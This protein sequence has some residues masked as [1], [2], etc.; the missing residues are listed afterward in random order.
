MDR[1]Q[2][3]LTPPRLATP[4]A[5]TVAM[6]TFRRPDDLAVAIPRVL[7]QSS[8]I[9]PAATLLI[10]DNDPAA[11]AADAVAAFADPRVRYVHEPRPGIAAARNRALDEVADD[12]LL[13][14]ID[15][16]ERP[17]RRLAAE[18]RRHVRPH[19]QCRRGR[20][21]RLG[22]RRRTRPVD[23]AR[24]A[25]SIDAA[26][27]P[28]RRID[29]AATNNL[30]LDMTQVRRLGLEFDEA[31]GISGGSDT[32][33]SRQLV[34]RGA[35]MVWCDEAVV[36]DQVPA[37]Q[38][39]ARVGAR[40]GHSALA[41]PG[42]GHRP[43]SRRHR[44][45]GCARAPPAWP[46]GSSASWEA[47]GG[48]LPVPRCGRSGCGR[49]AAAPC[50]AAP[51][52][53]RP[54]PAT[55]ST[56]TGGRQRSARSRHRCRDR[57]RRGKCAPA[58]RR[59][60]QLRLARAARGEPDLTGG[61]E[62]SRRDVRRRRQLHLARRA[63][64]RRGAVPAARVGPGGP[65]VQPWL[66]GRSERGGGLRSAP[67]LRRPAPAEPRRVDRLGLGR[68]PR[69]SMPAPAAV[70][71]EPGDRASGRLCL[72]SRRSHRPGHRRPRRRAG[73]PSSPD[74]PP[75]S[76]AHASSSARAC[77]TASAGSTSGTSCI[78]RTSTCPAAA[79]SWA[80]A[81]ASPLTQSPTTTSAPRSV[82]RGRAG[83]SRRRTTTTT[84][85]TGCR[86]PQ[87]TSHRALRCAGARRRP[88]RAGGSCCAAAA[89][90]RW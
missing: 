65:A 54:Q 51:G 31:F 2:S 53:W 81:S 68:G 23:R 48:S 17:A 45:G 25:S 3:A 78:G 41:T 85:A 76:P 61:G 66:R 14:F 47:P 89:A 62:R 37:R 15:D 19:G 90:G 22:L 21:S 27:P 72:V 9:D 34:A 30:L 56:S 33:F 57:S 44:P 86:S 83:R 13:I 7:A 28:E 26:C 59:R 8:D 52:W 69:E 46:L 71:A 63:G 35:S 49:T 12:G 42:C 80:A 40:S 67:R 20:A 64:S 11:S 75:G 87:G 55:C 79:S 58:R 39:H 18:P 36:T 43:H 38:G 24:D 88:C 77:G 82:R 1:P 4:R 32:L 74:L 10:V 73:H 29:V 84:A 5:V 70:G 50:T 6:L 60:G 16:D